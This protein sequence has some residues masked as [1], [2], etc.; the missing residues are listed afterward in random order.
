MTASSVDSRKVGR[1]LSPVQSP[2]GLSWKAVM[3]HSLPVA[4]TMDEPQRASALWS[5]HDTD[6]I[7]SGDAF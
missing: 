1:D 4:L 5:G 6:L 7:G 2:R 3:D